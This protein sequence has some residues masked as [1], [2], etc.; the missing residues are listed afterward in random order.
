MDIIEDEG[1]SFLSQME[2][3]EEKMTIDQTFTVLNSKVL[4]YL[5]FKSMT[6][7]P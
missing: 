7:L 3:I 2:E 4:V 5:A 1:V 6:F